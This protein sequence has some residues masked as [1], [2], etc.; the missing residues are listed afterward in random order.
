MT[1][2]RIDTF[3]QLP[4]TRRLAYA[5]YG[6]AE[7]IPVF[8]FHDLPGSRLSWGLLPG[9][10]F[11]E[12]L[13]LIAPDRPGYGRS[14]PCP[15]RTLL[16]WAEDVRELADALEIKAFAVV[17]VSG[18]GPGALACAWKM[19]DRI[20]AAGIVAS[21]APANAP[22]VPEAMGGSDRFCIRLARYAPWLSGLNIRL[23]GKAI[24][25]DPARYIRAQQPKLHTADQTLL[26]RSD[27]GG[28]LAG[29]FAEALCGGPRGM[30]DDFAANHGY[31]W[32]F[33]LDQI[34]A[35][36][37]FWYGEFDRIAPPATGRYLNDA[38]PESRMTFLPDA[39]H[40]WVLVHLDDVLEAVKQM[41]EHPR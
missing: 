9:R 5:E 15:G 30:M 32:G 38:V 31:R 3:V 19:P 20:P 34:K 33:P 27:I 7:G 21:P 22:G 14:D 40:Y 12:G 17:G 26:Q 18:G 11:P 36:V 23:R 16:D 35:R 39:G 6:D 1:A 28:M 25:H 2:A 13:R 10:P 24:R 8:L 29:D 37:R 41:M 4:D